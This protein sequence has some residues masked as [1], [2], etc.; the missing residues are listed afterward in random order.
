M[1]EGI[2]VFVVINDCLSLNGY[3]S[4]PLYSGLR[5]LSGRKTRGAAH[6]PDHY[7]HP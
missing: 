2:G 6:D 4:P 5:P 3:R 1:V 7:P